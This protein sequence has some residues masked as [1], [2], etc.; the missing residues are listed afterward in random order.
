MSVREEPGLQLDLLCCFNLKVCMCS[1]MNVYS[2]DTGTKK[3]FFRLCTVDP[4]CIG[5]SDT[6]KKL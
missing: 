1:I 6:E 5:C 3:K 2:A 4:A